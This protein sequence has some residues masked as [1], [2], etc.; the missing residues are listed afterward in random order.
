MIKKVDNELVLEISYIHA[1]YITQ[2]ADSND[3]TILIFLND[4]KAIVRF[5]NALI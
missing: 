4:N 2:K 3:L 5:L 1:S